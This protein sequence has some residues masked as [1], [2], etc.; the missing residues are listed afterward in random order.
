MSDNSIPE[1]N[2]RKKLAEISERGFIKSLRKD[3]TG[4]GFTLETVLGIKENNI[5]KPDFTYKNIPVELKAQREHASSNITLIT[6]S[7]CWEPLSAKQIIEK[8]GYEDAKRRHGLK[9][10]LKASDFNSQ[11]LKLEIK[12]KEN[13]LNIIHKE[14]GIICYFLIDELMQKIKAKLFEN[15]LLVFADTKTRNGAE[16]F[17]YNKAVLLSKLSAKGFK[18]LLSEGLIVWEFR[19]HIKDSGGVRDHGAGFRLNKSH[20]D[21]L[22]EERE[23]IL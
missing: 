3:N 1:I 18:K 12:D 20:I 6:K 8:Y 14:D 17:H 15:L 23:I 19:M 9:V 4:I 11:G 21:E 2:I 22:Y 7:P 16:Y 13:K 10:T 5:G